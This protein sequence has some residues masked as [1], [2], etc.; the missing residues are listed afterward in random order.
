MIITMK[1]EINLH[2]DIGKIVLRNGSEEVSIPTIELTERDQKAPDLKFNVNAFVKYRWFNQRVMTA[3]R[4]GAESVKF[5]TTDKGSFSLFAETEYN[6]VKS[7]DKVIATNNAK[8]MQRAKYS[9]EYLKKDFFGSTKK[10][11]TTVLIEYS[12]DY[13]LKMLDT[14]GNWLILAP[15]VDND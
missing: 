12:T 15:R 3:N 10:E 4:I 8:D 1:D 9:A 6:T 5:L 7:I 11:D 14:L 13:P 2:F